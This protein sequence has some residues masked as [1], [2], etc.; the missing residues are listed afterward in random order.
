VNGRRLIVPEVVQTSAMD[1]GP[2]A[3][4]S[5]LHG[6]GI[7][8]SYGRLREA[9]QADIDGTSINALEDV[10]NLLG[11][12]AEQVMLP[13]EHLLLPEAQALPAIVVVRLPKGYPHFVVVWRCHGPFVQVMN[14]AS[15]RLWPRR[16]RFMYEVFGHSVTL[17]ASEWRQWTEHDDFHQPLER[18][19]R[20]LGIRHGKELVSQALAG[21]GWRDVAALEATTRMVESMRRS[22]AT[23]PGAQA[24]R[25]LTHIHERV[26]TS[27]PGAD[28]LLPAPYWTVLPAPATAD[29]EPQLHVR[30]CVLVRI[31]GRT[32]GPLVAPSAP[33]PA[34]PAR[35]DEPTAAPREPFVASAPA[36]A[37]PA[38]SDEP[39]AAPRE[40]FV[41]SAPPAPPP[42][43]LSPELAA[44]LQEPPENPAREFFRLLR[45]GGWS[46]PLTL[47]VGLL[48]IALASVLEALLFR[49]LLEVV[50]RLG[51]V[52]Q[53]LGGMAV[54][55]VFLFGLLLLELP[56]TAIQWRLGRHLD[57]RFRIAFL[58]KIPRLENRYLS[59]RPISDM[60][61]RS[62][63]LYLLHLLLRLLAQIV[64]LII[65]TSVVA[66]AIAWVH[67]RA[68]LP[69]L[70]A[71][72]VVV[73]IPLVAQLPLIEQE[74]RMRMH[75]GALGRFY[76]D[77]LLGL[78][79]IRAHG[80]E[81]AMLREHEALLVEWARA[82][83]ALQRSSVFFEGMQKLVGVVFLVWLVS[84]Y[85][86]TAGF[87]PALLLLLFWASN[88]TTLGN[89]ITLLAR[90]YPRY[91]NVAIRLLD[92]LG[93]PEDAI[94]DTALV[95][96]T[97]PASPGV[98]V[99]LQAVD[100]VAAGH[101]ILHGID[102]VIEPGSHV[103]IVGRSGA[104]KT[105]LVGTVLGWHR[106]ARGELTVDGEPL[107]GDTLLQLRRDLAWVDP[108]VQL[109]NRSC[110]ANLTYGS[111]ERAP[112][113][114]SWVLREADLLGVLETLPAGLQTMLGEGGGLISGG[115]GQRVR[116]G[117]AMMR[118]HARLV[119]LDEAFRGLDRKKRSEFLRRAR[120]LW[121][122]ATLLCVTHDVEDT[123]ELERVLVLEDGRIVEDGPP[124]ELAARPDSRY[125]ALLAAEREI[126]ADLSIRADWRRMRLERW[127]LD[128]R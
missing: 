41:A 99:R 110:L 90:Q 25:L 71:C 116:L 7:N 58:R 115:E 80:G 69:A 56:V 79:A 18:R 33:A 28:P 64:R 78:V 65:E 105:T 32:R 103:G 10:V 120:A 51:L 117:R 75:G 128:E 106:P 13:I 85:V 12:E 5:L 77:S 76:L 63:S 11:L 8:A 38:R 4:K 124:R 107:R 62:H 72:A 66:A 74:L 81:R 126:R 16:Q 52:Q 17:P 114:P 23:A 60:A 87:S 15:G 88:L 112:S 89:E 54:I 37:P 100:V 45:P 111:D 39:T 47:M 31:L 36:P 67:P 97:A 40:P 3:L 49:G 127:K 104:G 125:A 109:W 92:P 20:T 98:A 70:I 46:G 2:A 73:C 30:G 27:A 101:T 21:D 122:R 119:V 57:L 68:A 22:G 26:R 61:E 84:D 19:L 43:P 53:R 34:P 14:P 82:G 1:C 118:P 55:A 59:S 50:D 24:T 95:P 94:D 123:L 86:A 44:A 6:F 42:P 48:A 113:D 108:A 35:S 96:A 29:G 93:A 83:K 91:R 9:C 102:L 121:H